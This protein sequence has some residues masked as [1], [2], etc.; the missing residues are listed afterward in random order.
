MPNVR[1]VG[2]DWA[3]ES[4]K[5]AAVELAPQSG[6]LSLVKVAQPFSDADAGSTLKDQ[7]LIVVAVDTP[8][9]WPKDFSSFVS[10]W[11]ASTGGP[12]PPTSLS[13]SL[14]T[15][16]LVVKQET[17]KQPL[18]V[19]ADRIGLCA[20]SWVNVVTAEKVANRIDVGQRPT[21]ERPVI[22]VYPGAS[23]KVFAKHSNST[24][25][26]VE[27]KKKRA[28]REV[29]LKGLLSMFGVRDQQHLA[30]QLIGVGEED[31]D[32]ADAFLAALTA[33]AYLGK[34]P[35]WSVRRPSDTELTSAQT[36]GW[37]FFPQRETKN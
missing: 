10:T 20:R 28:S 4:K 26:E 1:V 7:G 16:D 35:G 34:L 36:E 3:T 19:S 18:S 25:D 17:G 15:T 5:R 27:F 12:P 6:V 11:S 24:V 8:F 14:R 23:L 30:K 32:A 37:I 22:E 13:F 21:P 2:V 31:S 9:G 29:A 33:L